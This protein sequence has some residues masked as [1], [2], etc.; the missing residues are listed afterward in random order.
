MCHRPFQF[1]I[2]IEIANGRHYVTSPPSVPVATRSYGGTMCMCL[3]GMKLYVSVVASLFYLS[4]M[5]HTSLFHSV[6][7][8][9]LRCFTSVTC[10]ILR[11]VISSFREA[12]HSGACGVS[13]V[14]PLPVGATSL[15]QRASRR[16]PHQ[17]CVRHGRFTQTAFQRNR[18]A[19]SQ[20]D[21]GNDCEAATGNHV[22]V[23]HCRH[24]RER[25][26]SR[27]TAQRH[28]ATFNNRRHVT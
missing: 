19:P 2:I 25:S 16:L 22:R 23:A 14:H 15:H 1:R 24:Q 8:L 4:N 17:P 26:R 27:S 11:F 13:N 18:V 12:H 5:S 6:T 3:S 20:S 9:I 7:C 10:L 21:D 28:H